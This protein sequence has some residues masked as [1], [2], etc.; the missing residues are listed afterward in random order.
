MENTSL[1]FKIFK[2]EKISDITPKELKR[3]YRILVQKYHP[4]KKPHGNAE[5]FKVIHN[6]YEYLCGLMKEFL[7]QETE[8]FFNNDFLYYSDESIY[9]ISKKRWVKVKG[10]IVDTKA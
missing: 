4:D 7:K 9:S 2:I 10:N 3:R 8:K 5:K 1:Y 6:A